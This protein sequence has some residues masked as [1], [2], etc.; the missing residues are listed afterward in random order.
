MSTQSSFFSRATSPLAFLLDLSPLKSRVAVIAAAAIISLLLFVILGSQFRQVEERLGDLGWTL[1]PSYETEQRITI[2]AIDEASLA[3]VGPWP[4]PRETMAELARAIDGAGAQLQIHDIVYS[5]LRQ[6]DTEL[7]SALQATNGAVLAQIPV[8]DADQEIQVGFLSHPLQQLACAPASGEA[9]IPATSSYLA[10][11]AVFADIAKGHITPIIDR[12]GAIRKS[13]ALVCIEGESYPAL[14]IAALLQA[15][16]ANSWRA[17]LTPSPSFF[18]PAQRLTLEAYPGLSIPLDAEGHLRI[19][20]ARHPSAFRA[21]SAVDVLNGDYDRSLFDNAWVLLGATAFGMSDIV[22]TPFDGA[23]PGVELQARMLASLLDVAIPYTPAIA[24][25]IALLL[26]LIAAAVLLLL[27]NREGRW[28]DINLALA[29]IVLPLSALLLHIQLLAT[30]NVWLGWITPAVFSVLAAANLLLLELSRVRRQRVRVFTNLSSYLP[31]NLAKEIAYSLPNSNVAARWSEATVLCADLRNFSAFTASRPAEESAA[32]LHFFFT[33]ATQIVEK[34]GGRLHE[35]KGDG[36]LAVW[37]KDDGLAANSSLSAA[38]DLYKAFHEDL[39]P[40]FAPNGL[41]P[42]DLGIGIEQGPVLVGTIGPAHRRSHT[43]LGDTVTLAI[44]IQEFTAEI[45]QPVLVG[46]SIARKL[47]DKRLQ[48]QGSFLVNGLIT[49]HTL[50]ALPA[51][52]LPVSSPFDGQSA[53][54][55]LRILTGGRE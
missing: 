39:L 34:H 15:I 45:A 33:R 21:V 22:P 32:M 53:K 55:A 19:S 10:S 51:G 52:L 48:S 54:P 1:S 50:Y 38:I 26:S 4:W 42:L 30:V 37:D 23:A 43:L 49:P 6:G 36:I 40:D 35:F 24:P 7:H 29:G 16:D 44:R 8:L 5:E 47:H 20:Y 28:S 41:Q 31:G 25:A 12:D 17:N 13:P 3:E 11:N 2:V 14:A 18:G 9:Q 46:S 27:A